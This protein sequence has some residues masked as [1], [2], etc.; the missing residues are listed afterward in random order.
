ME[1]ALAQLNPGTQ[2]NSWHSKPLLLNSAFL[3]VMASFLDKF[4]VCVVVENGNLYLPSY[5]VYINWDQKNRDSMGSI[6]NTRSNQGTLIC[7]AWVICSPLALIFVNSRRYKDW[8]PKE[9]D[10][11]MKPGQSKAL[12][13]IL[14]IHVWWK[15]SKSLVDA[16]QT[17]TTDVHYIC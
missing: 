15:R 6:Y 17:Q 13:Q 1:L 2:Q 16:R 5:L 9:L 7:P 8:L 11:F 4:S 12:W 10:W 14:Q 3:W